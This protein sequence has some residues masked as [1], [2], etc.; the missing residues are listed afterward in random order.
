MTMRRAVLWVLPAFSLACGDYG[1]PDEV[2]F[3]ELVATQPAAS[4]DFGT[5]PRGAAYYIDPT[6][7]VLNDQVASEVQLPDAVVNAIAAN[8]NQLGYVQTPD[9]NRADVGLKMSALIGNTQVYYPG[10]WCDYW[11]W[12]SCYYSWTYAGSYSTGTAILDMGDLHSVRPPE[13]TKL[14]VLWS[15]AL[16]GVLSDYLGTGGISAAGTQRVVDAVNR[17]FAQ[18]PY[19][20]VQ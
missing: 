7:K 10:Y 4:F 15:A 2:V 9:L 18:S 3:G 1:A 14:Q 6:V 11:Y 20:N 13:N 17:A 5:L 12:Y 19:L 16:Y 8:L